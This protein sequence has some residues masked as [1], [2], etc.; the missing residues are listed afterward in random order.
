MMCCASLPSSRA[1]M[2]CRGLGRPFELPNVALARPISRARSVISSANLSSLPAMP[3]ASAMQASLA[4]WMMTP[5]RRSSTDTR[6]WIGM[7]MLDVCDGAPPVRQALVLTMNSSVGLSRP[8][9]ISLNTT[10]AVI[11]LERLA[12]GTSSSAFFSNSTLP[13]SASIR[14]AFGAAVWNGSPGLGAGAANAVAPASAPIERTRQQPKAK[15]PPPQAQ[16]HSDHCH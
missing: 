10:S 13:L 16:S 7:N 6:L 4:D 5:C 2:S 14:I 1:V 9:L 3:S 15:R 8:C 12:G 11:S